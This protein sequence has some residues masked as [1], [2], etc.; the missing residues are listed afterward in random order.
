VSVIVAFAFCTRENKNSV[1]FSVL[2]VA[3]AAKES[4]NAE[5]TIS[6]K[7]SAASE[8]S[9]DFECKVLYQLVVS[10]DYRGI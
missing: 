9:V 8:L 5:R 3:A 2:V 10:I 1:L 6:I 4:V 7:L